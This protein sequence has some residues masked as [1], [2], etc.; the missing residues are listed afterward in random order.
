[1][2]WIDGLIEALLLPIAGTLL[3]SLAASVARPIL[4]AR[5]YCRCEAPV[6]AAD[7]PHCSTCGRSFEV[8]TG[9]RPND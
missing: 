2:D 6:P 8:I 4:R 7:S 9:D 1:M 3:L 5:Q